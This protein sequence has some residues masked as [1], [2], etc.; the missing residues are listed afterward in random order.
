MTAISAGLLCVV[1]KV[2]QPGAKRL[3]TPTQGLLCFLVSSMCGFRTIEYKYGRRMQDLDQKGMV[4][5]H[6]KPSKWREFQ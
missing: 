4:L 5:A 2:S 3:M 1:A 6:T